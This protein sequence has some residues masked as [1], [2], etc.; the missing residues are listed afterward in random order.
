MVCCTP[1]CRVLPVTGYGAPW[2]EPPPSPVFVP[3]HTV[4]FIT[5]VRRRRYQL[6]AEKGSSIIVDRR[7]RRRGPNNRVLLSSVRIVFVAT[8]TRGVRASEQS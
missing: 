8:R 1:G 7:R 2:S 5:T 4:E 3:G 6:A